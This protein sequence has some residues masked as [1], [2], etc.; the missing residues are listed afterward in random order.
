MSFDK[1]GFHCSQLQQTTLIK[2]MC[3]CKENHILFLKNPYK[4]KGFAGFWTCGW[5]LDER[6]VRS[7]HCGLVLPL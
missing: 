3:L 1:T 4:F 5:H 2:E 6:G 7:G